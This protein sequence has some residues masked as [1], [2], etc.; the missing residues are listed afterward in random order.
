MGE[1][2]FSM[3][4]DIN[5]HKLSLQEKVLIYHSQGC[6]L[7]RAIIFFSLV[8][9]I[10]DQIIMCMPFYLGRSLVEAIADF[11]LV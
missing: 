8:Q 4:Q 1:I 9:I 2:S 10:Y 3:Y 6:L 7:T 11:L 5:F